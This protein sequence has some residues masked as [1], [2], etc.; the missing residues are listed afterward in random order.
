MKI[1]PAGAQPG[2]PKPSENESGKIG[3]PRKSE[4]ASDIKRSD[5]I[6]TTRK[7]DKVDLSPRA[8]MIRDAQVD[9]TRL[10]VAERAAKKVTGA[11][12]EIRELSDT[13]RNAVERKQDTRAAESRRALEDRLDRLQSELAK[14]RFDGRKILNGD[15]IKV[16]SKDRAE[17]LKTP[18]ADKTLREIKS[19]LRKRATKTDKSEAFFREVREF[20][21]KAG[22][23][24]TRMA[25]EVRETVADVVRESSA[26]KLKDARD[27]E[28]VLKAAIEARRSDLKQRP[29]NLKRFEAHAVDLLK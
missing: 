8:R 24:R 2:Q 9:V 28:R 1:P 5:R 17:S 6:V 21:D 25:K 4:P 13:Y 15:S 18:D 16:R 12:K 29:P 3:E 26:T 11:E 7:T 14:E 19:D 20:A 10:Q 27:A 23:I 22:E